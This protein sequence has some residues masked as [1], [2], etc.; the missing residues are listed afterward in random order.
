MNYQGRCRVLSVE[1]TKRSN[2]GVDFIC[3]IHLTTDLTSQ[4]Y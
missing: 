4:Y 3:D 2:I 1:F